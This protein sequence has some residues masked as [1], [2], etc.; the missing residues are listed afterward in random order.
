VSRIRSSALAT[1]ALAVACIAPLATAA[2]AG[3]LSGIGPNQA[4]IGLVNGKHDHATI[5]VIC[6]GPTNTGHPAP[7]QTLAVHGGV[8]DLPGFTGS[9]AHQIV[10]T[11]P[12]AAGAL[13]VAFSRYDTPAPIPMSVVLP[14]GGT[15][16][17]VFSPVPTSHSA[18]SDSVVVTFFSR[19]VGP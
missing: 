16:K 19:T 6:P 9:R 15:S 13:S 2:A 3:G 12:T 7:G 4:F 18:I 1:A 17:V 14:C 11:L 5:E 10:A 8:D